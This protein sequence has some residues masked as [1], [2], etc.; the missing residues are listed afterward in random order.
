MAKSVKKKTNRRLKRSVRRTLGALCM[1]TSII[2]ATIPFPD[3]AAEPIAET[4]PYSYYSGAAPKIDIENPDISGMTKGTA[5]T[6]SKPSSGNWQMDWQFEYHA[7]S[8]GSDGFISKYNSQY[9]VD[10]IDLQYRVY[11]DYINIS[12]RV[13]SPGLESIFRKSRSVN[14]I[15]RRM[16]CRKKLKLRLWQAMSM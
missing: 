2:V 6:I 3:A 12:E 16:Q 7:T 13:I 10:E 4:I 8:A 15:L 14:T 9:Q 11:S 5:Y 1:I